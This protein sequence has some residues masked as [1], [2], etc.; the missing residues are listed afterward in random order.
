MDLPSVA[1]YP[2][3]SIEETLEELTLSMAR[4][5]LQWQKTPSFN[6]NNYDKINLTIDEEAEVATVELSDIS[7]ININGLIEAQDPFSQT[8]FTKGTG[9]YPYDRSSL[10][11]ALIHLLI[12]QSSIEFNKLLNPEEEEVSISYSISPTDRNGT[13]IHP[14]TITATMTDYPLV[15]EDGPNGY[16]SKGKAYL[17]NPV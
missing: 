8:S 5:F 12:Y 1:I 2:D 3:F 17:L 16:I 15:I 10:T 14:I 11:D 9:S 7:A 6:P 13:L 4:K